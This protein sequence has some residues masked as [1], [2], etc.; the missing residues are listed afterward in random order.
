MRHFTNSEV[1][2]RLSWSRLIPAIRHAFEV[3]AQSP[4]RHSH[5]IAV[6]DETD[7][8]LLLMPSWVP[9][10]YLGLKTVTVHPGN[11]RRNMP[12]VGSHYLLFNAGTGE[13]LASFEGEELTSRRTAA[14]SAVASTYLSRP[15]S[16]RLLVLGTGNMSTK[17]VEAHL[18][19]RQFDNV[20]IWGRSQEKAEAVV[21]G[22]RQ[23]GIDA[24]AVLD[25][26]SAVRQ[27]DVISCCT[28]ADEALFDGAWLKPGA[29][30]DLV[31]AF[32]PDM[33]E[34]DAETMRRGRVY[35]D[36]YAGARSEAGDLIQAVAS[37]AM[38]W[39]DLQGD[40]E[41]LTR[42]LVE[43]R[44]SAEEITVFKSVGVSLEDLAAAELCY[45]EGTTAWSTA[46]PDAFRY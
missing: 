3:G 26:E 25:L 27:A 9:G 5:A 14:A 33:K 19:V 11:G 21:R 46:D 45:K 13:L 17:L 34:A 28:L 12:A 23:S 43:G 16:R 6:P 31:G 15:D 37:G 18:F 42:G 8:S 44:G 35:V 2:A 20:Q 22:L 41:E 24:E 36:T 32:T 4:P 38:A 39:T 7:A 40:M 29:H 10:A 1:A 30:V